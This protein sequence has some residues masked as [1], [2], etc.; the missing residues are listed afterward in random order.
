MLSSPRAVPYLIQRMNAEVCQGRNGV[1]RYFRLDYMGSSEFEWGAIPE[2]LRRLRAAVKAEWSP[3]AIKSG[4]HVA[5][6]VGPVEAVEA[7]RTIFADQLGPEAMRFKEGTRI[8]SSY[9]P[10]EKYGKFDAWWAI[11]AAP[12]P[13]AIF[14]SEI[15][16]DQW[17]SAIREPKPVTK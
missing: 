17:L 7:A 14:K 6:F 15:H 5:Y 9:N 4:E 3:V 2:A 11:D 12:A 10:R 1:D 8:E 16:A 13:W